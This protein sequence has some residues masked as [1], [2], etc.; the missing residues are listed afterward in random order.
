MRAL[1]GRR[2][3]TIRSETA[4]A[5]AGA[6]GGELHETAKER[7]E[8][9]GRAEDD[10]REGLAREARAIVAAAHQPGGVSED[11]ITGVGRSCDCVVSVFVQVWRRVTRIRVWPSGCGWPLHSLISQTLLKVL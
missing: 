5:Q 8:H 2:R 3:P 10:G 4:G 6:H 1:R 11:G 7:T 9:D